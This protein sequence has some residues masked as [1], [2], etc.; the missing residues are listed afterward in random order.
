MVCGRSTQRTMSLESWV[1]LAWLL[2]IGKHLLFLFLWFFQLIMLFSLIGTLVQ[3]S[4]AASSNPAQACPLE[5]EFQLVEEKLMAPQKHGDQSPAITPHPHICTHTCSHC[6][7]TWTCTH[8]TK[9][10]KKTLKA[11]CYE[12]SN[13]KGFFKFIFPRIYFQCAPLKWNRVHYPKPESSDSQKHH[14]LT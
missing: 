12:S 1:C 4:L 11:K 6:S 9:R 7:C 3:P 5:T 2:H 13:E 10:K 14:S 8:R